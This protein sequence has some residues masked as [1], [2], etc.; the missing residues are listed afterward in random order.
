[1][2]VGMEVLDVLVVEDS[3][4]YVQVILGL[5]GLTGHRVRATTTIAEATSAMNAVPPDLVI[6]D[7][8]LP[9]GDGL[10]LCRSIRE[11]SDAYVIM[12][13]GRDDE[14]D[15]VV[16]LRLGADD[17]VTKPFSSRE[18]SARIEALARRPRA[19]RTE[20]PERVIDEL[21]VRPLAREV[22]ISGRPV[23]LTRIEFDLLDQLTSHP[24]QVLTR[25]QLLDSVWGDNWFGGD[26]V[27]DV[28][29]ANLRKKLAEVSDL[30][31]V[32]TV[33]GVG[34]GLAL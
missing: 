24:R 26:H 5:A 25:A 18:L 9:D 7:L 32:R 6:L 16:G 27:V 4:E 17:Y 34:Y 31:I 29:I 21:V 19:Q 12:L 15:K 3:P 2:M 30:Q 1:M 23:E 33:R 20:V 28:H 10:D 8:N 22:E 14:V 13:T 11:R